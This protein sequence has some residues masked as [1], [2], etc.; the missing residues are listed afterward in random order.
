MACQEVHQQWLQQ[1]YEKQQV[2]PPLA[3]PT[4]AVSLSLWHNN[5]SKGAN[6]RNDVNTA[7][8]LKKNKLFG[9]LHAFGSKCMMLMLQLLLNSFQARKKSKK[10]DLYFNKTIQ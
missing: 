8:G 2:N 1:G 9:V 10:Y 4:D 7:L 3:G 5:K 6:L